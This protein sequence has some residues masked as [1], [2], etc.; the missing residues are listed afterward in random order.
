MKL[1]ANDI[2]SIQECLCSYKI[3]LNWVPAITEEDRDLKY[4]KLQTINHLCNICD[5]LLEE[6]DNG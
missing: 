5:D 3:L 6:M 4:I 2:Y 1:S